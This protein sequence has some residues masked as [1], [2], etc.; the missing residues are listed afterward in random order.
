MQ[1][2]GP[3]PLVS[4][5]EDKIDALLQELRDLNILRNVGSNT[6]LL[7][8]KNFRDLLGSD[9]KIFEKLSEVTTV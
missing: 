6:Y 1:H 5:D 9:D 3:N 8:S 2:S 7:A 4:L